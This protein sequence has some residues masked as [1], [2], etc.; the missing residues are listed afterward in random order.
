VTGPEGFPAG[1]D[2]PV[3]VVGGG[4]AGLSASYCLATRGVAHIVLERRGVAW[5]WRNRRWDSFCLVTP[6]WQCQLPGHPY[7]GADPDGFMLLDE[8]VSYI[9]DYVEETGPPLVEGVEVTSLRPGAA[10]GFDVVTDGGALHAGQ[11]VI[12]SGPYNVAVTPRLAASLPPDVVQ[13]HSGEYR[14]PEA[15]PPGAVAVIGTGQSG[16]QI[17]EDLHLAGRT[18]HLATGTAP[19]VARRYRGKDV[20]RWLD[21]MGYYATTVADHPLGEEKRRNVNHYV[22]GRDGG[23][24]ID[25]RVFATEGMELYGRLRAVDGSTMRFGDELAANLD[26]ADAVAESIKDTI[27]RWIEA[28]DV[29]APA[30]ARRAPVWQPPPGPRQLDLVAEGVGSVIWCTGFRPEYGWIELPV[31]DD[32]GRPRHTRGVTEVDGVYFLGLPWLNTWGSAR[33]SGI[34][35]DAEHV[36]SVAA[37]R[38]Q[39]AAVGRT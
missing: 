6:N 20:V 3:V 34:A 30:E 7:R 12:A 8:V 39:P 23:H 11:V 5:E 31:F 2:V 36:A 28:N 13:L 1:C 37:G 16:C 35:A 26:G 32:N 38:I 9:E 24:D 33:F 10:D 27:D 18:V 14:N 21:E 15:L 19:R 17:A 4:Q 25:L 22:T 29:D